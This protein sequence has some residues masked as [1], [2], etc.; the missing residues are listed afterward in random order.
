VI[1]YGRGALRDAAVPCINDVKFRWADRVLDLAASLNPGGESM[2]SLAKRS[3]PLALAVLGAVAAAPGMAT[4][5]VELSID[6]SKTG[7]KIDRNIFGQ[8]AEHLG[9]GI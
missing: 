3:L 4:E 6:V 5:K 7:P 9:H 8:F 2:P 1:T